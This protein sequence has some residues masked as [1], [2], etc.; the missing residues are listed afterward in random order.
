M[1]S[2]IVTAVREIILIIGFVMLG[3]GLYMVYVP[4]MFIVCGALMIFATLPKGGD[5]E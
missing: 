5:P 1:N 3:V 4:L 2:K